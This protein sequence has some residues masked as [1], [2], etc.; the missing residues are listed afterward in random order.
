MI[1]LQGLVR[2]N[3]AFALAVTVQL[4]TEMREQ[5]FVRKC[6]ARA[7]GTVGVPCALNAATAS[8][9][10]WVILGAAIGAVCYQ[11]TLQK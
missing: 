1:G 9:R 5:V 7:H 6:S 4:A 11:W 10:R 8:E 3:E 2:Y